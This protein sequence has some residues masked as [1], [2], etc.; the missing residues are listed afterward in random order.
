MIAPQG[1]SAIEVAAGFAIG[2]P[3]E[4]GLARSHTY[5]SPL[6][7]LTAAV[8]PHVR[9]GRCAVAFSGGRDSAL[10]LAAAVRAAR[11]SGAPLPVA[12]T[13]RYPHLPETDES[14]W[15]ELVIRHLGVDD[16]IRIDVGDDLDLIGAV[17]QPLLRRHGPLYPA[18]SHSN[19]PLMDAARGGSL[20]IG[21][22]GDELLTRRRRQ[23]LMDLLARRRRPEPR[24]LRL[25]AGV[26]L[27]RPLRRRVIRGGESLAAPELAWLTPEGRDLVAR[28]ERSVLDE[29]ARWSAAVAGAARDRSLELTVESL[30]RI[31]AAEGV[32]V[33]TP[34]LDARF[35][36]ALARAG[37]L[38]GWGSRTAAMRAIA[39]DVLPG[40]ILVRRSKAFFNRSFFGPESRAFAESWSGEGVDRRLVDADRLRAAWREPTPDFRSAML[41]QS[42][43][44]ATVAA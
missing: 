5:E 4:N 37:G 28:A 17:A 14:R 3:V 34:L 40:E 39:G 32:R 2:G 21:I 43:W 36:V 38:T 27:P 23:A 33:D 31:G 7:A 1:L 42:A 11:A 18:N 26:L 30:R 19:M 16:W 6:A 29:P 41:L 15:Q 25:L 35:V 44:V 12:L 24:D 13:L 22:G 20:L 10:I 9:A 8:E